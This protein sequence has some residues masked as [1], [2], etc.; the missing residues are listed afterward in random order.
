MSRLKSQEEYNKR[1]INI[2]AELE[3]KMNMLLPH[4]T[5]QTAK[6]NHCIFLATKQL[7]AEQ[8]LEKNG[9]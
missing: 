9:K 4:L 7:E 3:N 6:I 5:G 8:K 1:S 2:N